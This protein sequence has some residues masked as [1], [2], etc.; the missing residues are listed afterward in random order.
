MQKRQ[1]FHQSNPQGDQSAMT[2]QYKVVKLHI[3]HKT[4]EHKPVPHD[5]NSAH[6]HIKLQHSKTWDWTGSTTHTTGY[7]HSA[8]VQKKKKNRTTQTW[9][10]Y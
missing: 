4:S 8:Y 1:L 10:S 5:F 3:Q 6:M 2:D 9:S 7:A